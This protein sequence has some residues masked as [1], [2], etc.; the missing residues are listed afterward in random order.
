MERENYIS[1]IQDYWR[2]IQDGGIRSDSAS[3]FQPS[4]SHTKDDWE[5]RTRSYGYHHNRRPYGDHTRAPS[6]WYH[7]DFHSPTYHDPYYGYDPHLQWDNGYTDF[8][9]PNSYTRSRRRPYHRGGFSKHQHDT[10]RPPRNQFPPMHQ[11]FWD[12][13]APNDYFPTDHHRPPPPRN[14]PPSKQH[15]SRDHSPH[16]NQPPP[17]HQHF[18]GDPSSPKNQS[19]P[20][21]KDRSPP[22]ESEP[23]AINH[24]PSPIDHQSSPKSQHSPREEQVA[25]EDQISP[26]QKK[27]S[28]NKPPPRGK[29]T[30]GRGRYK[31][32]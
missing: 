3:S 9:V 18:T 23:S 17:T 31:K 14:Q 30:R 16:R 8:C 4:P 28:R 20:P 12:Y 2:Y 7:H 13:P 19:Y 26:K 11:Q 27:A 1:E 6:Q 32:H 15:F 5:P 22:R 24:Q 21:T 10:R 29:R 25:L